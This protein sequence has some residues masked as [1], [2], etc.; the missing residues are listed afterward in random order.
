MKS[1][2]YAVLVLLMFTVVACGL[3]FAMVGCDG[4]GDGIWGTPDGSIQNYTGQK[5]IVFEPVDK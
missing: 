3:L 1:K 4:N 2:M 5:E